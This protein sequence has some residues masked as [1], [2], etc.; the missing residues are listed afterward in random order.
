MEV[1]MVTMVGTQNDFGDTLIELAELDYDAVEAYKKA[2]EN[3]KNTSFREKL[4]S[5]MEDHE[6]HVKEINNILKSNNRDTVDKPSGKQYLTKGKVMLADMIGDDKTILKAMLSNEE[7]TVTAYE[8]VKKHKN[9]WD[10]SI[11]LINKGV[12]DEHKHREWISNT[13][14]SL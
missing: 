8:K 5:F 12:E 14:N 7:D 1:P 10:D 11:D 6:K 13:I 4:K 3:I 9:M 2:I